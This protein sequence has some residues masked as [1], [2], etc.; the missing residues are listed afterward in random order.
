MSYEAG[1][2]PECHV[3]GGPCAG[4]GDVS[5]VCCPVGVLNPVDSIGPVGRGEEGLVCGGSP[6]VE[7][8]CLG[9]EVDT[10]AY[11]RDDFCVAA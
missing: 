11:G 6:G 4:A 2:Y 3:D 7:M 9:E 8:S 1:D 5:A 10:R